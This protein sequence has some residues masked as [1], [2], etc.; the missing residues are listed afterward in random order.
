[1]A[2]AEI[3]DSSRM[4]TS[5]SDSHQE[6]VVQASEGSH[7]LV[8]LTS[9]Y[10]TY[11][12]PGRILLAEDNSVLLQIVVG[13]MPMPVQDNRDNHATSRPLLAIASENRY[14]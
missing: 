8:D 12:H 10:G 1:M 2:I 3:A 6:L 9:G 13:Y 7:I 5:S 4:K 14:S 11:F